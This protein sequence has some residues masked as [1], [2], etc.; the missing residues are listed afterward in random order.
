MAFK[1][2]FGSRRFIRDGP[3]P[4]DIT[5]FFSDVLSTD[6]FLQ[7]NAADNIVK[8]FRM[9]IQCSNDALDLLV[10]RADK[11]SIVFGFLACGD[12]R[13]A[14]IAYNS[15][16]V[17]ACI[18]RLSSPDPE[19]RVKSADLGTWRQTTSIMIGT[20]EMQTYITYATMLLWAI[21]H[22]LKSA[23]DLPTA[24][25]LRIQ[26][27]LCTII[28]SN[29]EDTILEECCFGL[30]TILQINSEAGALFGNDKICGRLVRL[31]ERGSNVN[32]QKAALQLVGAL[33][34]KSE[35]HT[36]RLLNNNLLSALSDLVEHQLGEDACWV[37]SNIIAESVE[38]LNLIV[39]HPK[40]LPTV[41]RLLKVDASGF[42]EDEF[43]GRSRESCA[44]LANIINKGQLI[45]FGEHD[46][47]EIDG[48]PV[49][50]YLKLFESS[51]GF[52]GLARL[53]N[54]KDRPVAEAAQQML[55]L[56][57]EIMN[58]PMT[59]DNEAEMTE[60]TPANGHPPIA[61]HGGPEDSKGEEPNQGGVT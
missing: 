40:I 39:Y 9:R 26:E 16:I 12:T 13:H 54:R 35:E 45:L 58:P 41:V 15:G 60:D 56:I 20:N 48:A 14:T 53:E 29:V 17:P 37:I 51:G 43:G 47:I 38:H 32:I 23:Q 22:F 21:N 61:S 3:R 34:A 50:L 25:V 44:I 10:T 46:P 19:A 1:F 55:A 4:E 52:E 7:I 49:N 24:L 2:E 33:T 18:E 31:L 28:M 36:T 11:A 8:W 5:V 59:V 6:S 57:D 27:L 42:D 30:A